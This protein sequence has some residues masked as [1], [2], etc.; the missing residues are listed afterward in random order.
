[1]QRLPRHQRRV[2]EALFVHGLTPAETARSL[3]YRESGIYQIT[4]RAKAALARELKREGYGEESRW[5][6]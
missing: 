5:T 3:G 2:L 1:M 4:K 6:A